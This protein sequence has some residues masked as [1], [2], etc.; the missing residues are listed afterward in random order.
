[1][2]TDP[3]KDDLDSTK[4]HTCSNEAPDRPFEDGWQKI[5]ISMNSKIYAWRCLE[6][7][8]RYAKKL[9]SDRSGKI[10]GSLSMETW[11]L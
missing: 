6:C 9:I 8:K 7:K 2:D 1:M 10:F 5:R 11:E 4:C 3:R